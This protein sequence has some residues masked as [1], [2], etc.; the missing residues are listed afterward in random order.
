[1]N[2]IYY[3]I[4]RPI[5]SHIK[6]GAERNIYRTITSYIKTGVG[7][8][9]SGVNTVTGAVIDTKDTVIAK[10]IMQNIGTLNAVKKELGQ[11]GE[12][13]KFNIEL[14]VNAG[15]AKVRRST[16]YDPITNLPKE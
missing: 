4:Y 5:T 16:Q 3:T 13:D 11:R 9:I 10:A 12:K 14:T 7:A 15:I 2:R 8:T 1:M 6:Y